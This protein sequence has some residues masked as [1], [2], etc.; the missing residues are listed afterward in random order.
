MPGFPSG[1]GSKP[2]GSPGE[3]PHGVHMPHGHVNWWEGN[4]LVGG[5]A[6]ACRYY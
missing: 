4:P 3:H 1:S 2:P 6:G 5:E